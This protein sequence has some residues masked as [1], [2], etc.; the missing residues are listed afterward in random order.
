ME[1]KV[2]FPIWVVG[3]DN[4]APFLRGNPDVAGAGR[5][6]QD[7]NGQWILG[8][9]QAWHL[10]YR[11]V[12][13]EMD[14]KVVRDIIVSADPVAPHLAMLIDPIRDLLIRDWNVQ[15]YVGMSMPFPTC[16]CAPEFRLVGARNARSLNATRLGSVHLPG[17]ARRTHVRRSRRLPFY[18]PKVEGRQVTRV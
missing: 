11:R 18:D 2:R 10:G 12:D 8:L 5:L 17:D 6:I 14:S 15:R 3:S 9:E 7:D 4:F 13:L 1:R 16:M